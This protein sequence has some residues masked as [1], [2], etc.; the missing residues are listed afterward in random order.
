M[1]AGD[2]AAL[3]RNFFSRLGERIRVRPLSRNQQFCLTKHVEVLNRFNWDGGSTPPASTNVNRF[4]VSFENV[5]GK[6]GQKRLGLPVTW[7]GA[8]YPPPFTSLA[9]PKRPRSG[10]TY[11]PCHCRF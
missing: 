3:N 1:E 9:V 2:G 6:F 5:L 7:D 10:G 8:T 4:K 11:Y